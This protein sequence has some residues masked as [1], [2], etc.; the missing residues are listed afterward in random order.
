MRTTRSGLT[1]VTSWTVRVSESYNRMIAQGYAVLRS[2]I[3][4]PDFGLSD[5]QREL[6]GA[7][8]E[9]VA[10]RIAPD[11]AG[12]EERKEFPRQLFGQLGRMGL[13]GIPWD[14]RFGG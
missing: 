9:L 8:R 11:I 3:V 6:I 14:E 4:D 7:V 1:G 5:E 12:Y 10:E 2:R 13:T